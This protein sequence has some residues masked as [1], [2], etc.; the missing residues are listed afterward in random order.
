MSLLISVILPTFNR[1]HFLTKAIDSVLAQSFEN[2]ELIIVDNSSTDGT[3][4]LLSKYVD[5]RIRVVF[6]RNGGNI[7]YSLNVGIQHSKGTIIGFLNSDDWW[8]PDKLERQIDIFKDPEIGAVYG[9]YFHYDVDSGITTRRFKTSLPTGSLLN[10]IL[11]D[12]VI[13]ILTVLIR[14]SVLDNMRSAFDEQYR[15][16]GD[17]DL[18]V[19]IAIDWKIGCVQDPVATYRWHSNSESILNK[20]GFMSDLALWV[21]N[22]SSDKYLSRQKGFLKRANMIALAIG[23]YHMNKGQVKEAWGRFLQI[24]FSMSKFKYFCFVIWVGCCRKI[25]KIRYSGLFNTPTR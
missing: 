14:R 20:D 17:F 1:A 21:E 19:R 8:M 10:N 6:V 24:P 4:E 5:P 22:Y 2:W 18:M 7:S 3:K 12:Y 16:I 15:L 11:S 13:G 9:N 23:V 25:R